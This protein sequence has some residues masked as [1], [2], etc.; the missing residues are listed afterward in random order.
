MK[1]I[2]LHLFEGGGASLLR[3]RSIVRVDDH[4]VEGRRSVTTVRHVIGNTVDSVKVVESAEEI[5]RLIE[6]SADD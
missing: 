2:T 3:V 5:K 1:F 4:V 6:R